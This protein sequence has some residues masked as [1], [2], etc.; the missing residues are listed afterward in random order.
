[1]D[2]LQKE[3]EAA[4]PVL[5]IQLLG[6]NAYGQ[7]AANEPTTQDRELPWLQ[8][9]DANHDGLGDAAALWN[10]SY[11]DVYILDGDNVQVASFDVDWN[12]LQQPANYDALRELLIDAAMTSQR[13]WHNADN[14]LDVNDNDGVEPLDA[15][16]IINNLN[17]EGPHQL[18]PPQ[19]GDPPM[20]YYDCNGDGEVGPIDA[21]NVINYLNAQSGAANAEGEGLP[22]ESHALQ[23]A[24]PASF[25]GLAPL[26][27]AACARN[28]SRLGLR[29][30][31][32]G[33]ASQPTNT[34]ARRAHH[35]DED[36]SREAS[37]GECDAVR[38][39]AAS[40]RSGADPAKLSWRKSHPLEPRDGWL[41]VRAG[42]GPLLEA[43]D[44]QAA[45]DL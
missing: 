43:A 20:R 4:Y 27:N 34:R 9:V 11:R 38:P 32:A 21:L 40:G 30:D 26:P 44:G 5:R 39:D 41:G 31:P 12:D 13:P 35:T 16:T 15:L 1:M 33:T 7:D 17:A 42:D 6:V 18:P 19:A 22:A 10:P 28:Q 37:A 3:L 29:P 8:D 25:A 14:P 2:D 36:S 23:A 24:Q 45:L